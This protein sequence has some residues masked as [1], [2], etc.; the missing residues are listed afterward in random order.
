LQI[1]EVEQGEVVLI[2]GD[3]GKYQHW[4]F[5]GEDG[6]IIDPLEHARA[7]GKEHGEN[8]ASWVFNGPLPDDTSYA[9]I[10][11]G[12]EDGDP[13]VLDWLP[14]Y[15]LGRSFPDQGDPTE[16]LLAHLGPFEPLVKERGMWRE[17][18]EELGNACC[19]AFEEAFRQAVEFTV[20]NTCRYH[21]EPEA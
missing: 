18:W 12:I 20:A 9:R 14:Q 16:A 13:A 8:A 19:D 21:L 5:L 10:L 6:E 11:Q 3:D 17:Q 1:A 2:T 4:R 15:D 7:M